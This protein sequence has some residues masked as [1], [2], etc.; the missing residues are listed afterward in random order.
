[1]RERKITKHHKTHIR[2]L[3]THEAARLIYEEGVSQYHTAKS[4]AFKNVLSAGGRA[5]NYRNPSFLPSNGE[6][7][8]AVNRLADL[9]EGEARQNRLFDMRVLALECMRQ[10]SEFSPRLIGSVSTGN[11]K[12]SSDIDI[13]IFT[14]NIE[15]LL[16]H[17]ASLGWAYERDDI[18]IAQQGTYKQ[19]THLY[20]D[21]GYPVELSVY[22]E[23]D[24]RIRTRSSTDGKPIVRYSVNKLLELI[25]VEHGEQWHQLLGVSKSGSTR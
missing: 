8:E 7:C 23:K 13:H 11:I 17:L 20:I 6:I 25:L 18:T 24:I 16:S 15:E 1:M 19:Y 9:Y 2:Q 22:T 14:D 12:N 4:M 5:P 3:I 21:R 10:L